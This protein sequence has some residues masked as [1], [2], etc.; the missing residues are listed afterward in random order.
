[1]GISHLTDKRFK[2][3]KESVFFDHLL[4]FRLFIKESS[5]IK[6]DKPVLNCTGTSCI[7]N[8]L[9]NLYRVHSLYYIIRILY[10]TINFYD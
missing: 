2:N 5:V 3:V 7:L 4:S 9:T 6:C 1:M 10:L 8:Y